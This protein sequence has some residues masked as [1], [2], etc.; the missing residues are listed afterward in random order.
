MDNYGAM[1]K[2]AVQ[3]ADWLEKEWPDKEEVWEMYL[4][5]YIID[6]YNEEE[7]EKWI[8]DMDIKEVE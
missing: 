3:L 5:D 6:E 4:K 2:K 1:K 7:V 8:V